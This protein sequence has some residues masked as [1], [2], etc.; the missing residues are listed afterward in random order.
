MRPALHDHFADWR[1]EVPDRPESLHSLGVRS[2]TRMYLLRTGYFGPIRILC[3]SRCSMT[4]S[5][6]RMGFTMTKLVCESYL[7]GQRN[8]R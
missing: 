4:S 3:F 7:L 1:H 8:R 2:E 6:E 5:G